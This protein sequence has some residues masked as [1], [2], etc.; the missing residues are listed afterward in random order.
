MK[1]YIVDL[2]VPAVLSASTS[3]EKGLVHRIHTVNSSPGQ[4]QQDQEE[5]ANSPPALDDMLENQSNTA[6]TQQPALSES[7]GRFKVFIR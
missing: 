5:E 2:K 4:A 7:Y 3:K 6:D 1:F